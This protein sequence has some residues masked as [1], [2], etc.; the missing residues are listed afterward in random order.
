MGRTRNVRRHARAVLVAACA[1]L[2]LAP[3]AAWGGTLRR[4]TVG[5]NFFDPPKLTIKRGDRVRWTWEPSIKAHDVRV[6]SGPERFR[7]PTQ[8][9]GTYTR[10][11]R[12]AGTFKL[13]CSRHPMRMTLVVR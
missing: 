13:Y 4:V 11:F 10:T 8:S 3:T 5:S 1:L 12:K 6:R 2:A 7:S 9:S